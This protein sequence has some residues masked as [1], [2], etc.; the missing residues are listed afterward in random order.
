MIPQLE[1]IAGLSTALETS[2]PWL[3]PCSIYYV[4]LMADSLPQEGIGA[5]SVGVARV[6][7]HLDILFL[8]KLHCLPFP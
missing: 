6:A 3:S 5:L 7:L 4:Y 8:C 1:A 2:F